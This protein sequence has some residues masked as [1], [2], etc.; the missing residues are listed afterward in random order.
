MGNKVLLV[1]DNKDSRES[2]KII[3][4]SSDKNYKIIDTK[5]GDEGFDAALKNMPDIIL[6]DNCKPAGEGLKTLKKIRKEEST[7]DIPVILITSFDSQK[8]LGDAISSGV[9]DCINI[10]IKNAELLLRVEK[11]MEVRELLKNAQ[12]SLEKF[13]AEVDELE[14]RAMIPHSLQNSFILINT[15]GELEWANDGFRNLHGYK[16]EEF[17]DRH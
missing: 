10:P 9:T 7:K 1:D 14:K 6:L 15:N 3:L 16:L 8:N 17:K 2:I 13:Q 11:N 4:T 5:N 12:K